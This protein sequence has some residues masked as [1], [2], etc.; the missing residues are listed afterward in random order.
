MCIRD[1]PRPRSFLA[2]CLCTGDS[3]S[4]CA[5]RV[6]GHGDDFTSCALALDDGPAL[7]GDGFK[8]PASASVRAPVVGRSEAKPSPCD[9]RN[10]N[11]ERGKIGALRGWLC[12]GVSFSSCTLSVEGHGPARAPCPVPRRRPRLRR[13]LPRRPRPR[14]RRLHQLLTAAPEQERGCFACVF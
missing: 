13:P 12:A 10:L 4:S 5:L 8:L 1:R 11:S 14:R 9:M 2:R 7:D 3:F 6:E